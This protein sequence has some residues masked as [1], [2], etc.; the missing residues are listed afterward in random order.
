MDFPQYILIGALFGIVAVTVYMLLAAFD[1][2][3]RRV[4]SR[5]DALQQDF[6][7]PVVNHVSDFASERTAWFII[8]ALQQIG[9]HPTHSRHQVKQR[10]AKAGIYHP[11]APLRFLLARLLF[12]VTAAVLMLAMGFAGF[13]RMDLALLFSIVAG[14]SG[15][16]IPS[17]W[18]DRAVKQHHILLRKSLPDFLDLMI[19]CLE[20]GMSLQETIRRVSDELLLAHPVFASELGTVQREIELGS[21]V[22][23]ALKH[24]AN[25][26]DYEG[27]RT[28]SAFIRE[29]QRFGT[30][31]TEALRSHADMLRSQREQAAEENAQKVAVKILLPTLLL[32]FP[33]IFVVAVGPAVIQIQ[34]AFVAK[35][36]TQVK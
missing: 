27:L 31:I 15:A 24:F 1:P 5:V 2:Y 8:D 4:Q 23:Q 19:I 16:I 36:V 10:L 18:L 20:G 33:A 11:S 30:N 25:R 3:W 22:D 32:I 26:A 21:T 12:L 17:L 14:A 6:K 13:M 35:D 7:G 29:A 9:L 34:E 28:L